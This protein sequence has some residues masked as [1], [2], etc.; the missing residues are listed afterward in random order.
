MSSWTPVGLITTE[1]QWELTIVL[2]D[3]AVRTLS[4][5]MCLKHSLNF[6]PKFFLLHLL[7]ILW[8]GLP[9][10]PCFGVLTSC[11]PAGQE[12]PASQLTGDRSSRLPAGS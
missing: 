5:E 12:A 1:P 7:P 8:C 9:R 6:Q 4:M 3:L 10:S 11:P 2:F